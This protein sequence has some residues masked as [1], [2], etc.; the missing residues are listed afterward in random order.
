MGRLDYQLATIS[1]RLAR[2]EFEIARLK[3][4]NDVDRRFAKKS[5]EVAKSE[6]SRSLDSVA[7]FPKSISK[8]ELDRLRLVVEK[9][10]LSIEQAER[11]LHEASLTKSLKEQTVEV[12]TKQLADHQI[13]APISGMV[14]QVFRK[15]GEWLN[16]G[17]PVCE[18]FAWIDFGS[19]P[20]WT[21]HDSPRTW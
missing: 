17:D 16:K 8:T 11:D 18:S 15:P 20:S 12:A 21:V 13:A 3:A 19:K 2:T 10:D 9:T 14:V 6:L 5:L 4:E 7:N 1:E